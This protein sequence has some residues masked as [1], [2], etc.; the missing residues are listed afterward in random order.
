M[1]APRRRTQSGFGYTIR[2]FGLS[3]FVLST[4]A[5]YAVHEHFTGAQDDLLLPG[6]ASPIRQ[7]AASPQSAPTL[8]PFPTNVPTNANT[9]ALPTV[10][11]VTNVLPTAIPLIVVTQAP[12]TDVPPTA[13]PPTDVPP[14]TIPTDIPAPTDRPAGQ[15]AD[16]TYT[17]PVVDAYYGNVQ[18]QAV[19]Q[20]GQIADVQFLDYPHDRRTSQR[21]NS[22]ATPYLTQEAI[23]AQNGNVN[24]ISGATLTS[25][26]FVE[27]LSAALQS[28]RSG[29]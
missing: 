4:F 21:I 19:V 2:K 7:V 6:D 29:I 3:A 15:Y 20:N 26:A 10:T 16:G 1:S 17:G 23:Q 28:A 13:V 27:S 12:P 25:Q 11:P 14:T 24:I 22:Q 5:A 18:V 9:S 8:I